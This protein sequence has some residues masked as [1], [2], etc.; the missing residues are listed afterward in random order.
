MHTAVSSQRDR[1]IWEQA[2]LYRQMDNYK[3]TLPL[4]RK[5]PPMSSPSTTEVL[6]EGILHRGDMPGRS[7]NGSVPGQF[8]L[9]FR[10]GVFRH[11]SIRWALLAVVA[12]L[13]PVFPLCT[14]A[15]VEISAGRSFS[16]F[17]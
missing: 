14:G 10:P 16:V 13:S 8:R 17:G 7:S 5:H 9:D 2:R 15:G 6:P 4:I 11:H 12:E 3:S 1:S